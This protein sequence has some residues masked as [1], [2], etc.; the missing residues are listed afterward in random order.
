MSKT[1]KKSI[2]LGL[3]ILSVLAFGL[4]VMPIRASA[5]TIRRAG[6]N[7]TPHISSISPNSVDSYSGTSY[8]SGVN[9]DIVVAITGNGFVPSS[10]A[11]VNGTDRPTAFID[12]SHVL[13]KIFLSDTYNTDGFY[14]NIFNEAPGGGYSNSKFF[15]IK[16]I[17][18]VT[19][20][21]DDYDYSAT[22]TKNTKAVKKYN[23]PYLSTTTKPQN[24]TYP[25][26]P[27]ESNAPDT[28]KDYSNIASNAI[29]GSNTFLP[30]GLTQWVLFGIIILLIVIFVR[31]VFSAKKHYEESPMKHA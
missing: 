3:K 30:S 28:G 15:T 22:I 9:S 18:P 21:S 12:P 26:Y 5:I 16:S 11:R 19:S 14:V 20:A 7:P 1:N 27:Y 17:A 4:L 6:D 10:V 8:Y 23:T 2:V 13:I 31:R 25:S 24:V 29:F